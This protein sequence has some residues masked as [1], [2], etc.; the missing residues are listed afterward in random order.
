MVPWSASHNRAA[1]F[2]QDLQHGLQVEGR[3]ADDLEHVGGGGLLLQRFAQLAEQ[4]GI[5]DGDDRLVRKGGHQLDLLGGKRLRHGLVDED[6][7]DDVAFAQQR[8]AQRG[9]VAADLLR[10][11][12]GVFRVRQNVGNVDH[13]SLERDP[14]GHAAAIGADLQ[15]LEIVPDARVHLAGMTVAGDPAE[16][17]A[18]ALEQPGMIGLA[19]PRH[20]LDQRIEH[21]LQVEGRAADDL[22]HVGGGGLLLQ[23]LAQLVEQSGILDGDDRLGGEALDQLDLLVGERA[24][25]LP[26]DDENADQ[27]PFLLQRHGNK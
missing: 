11:A 14:P 16:V 22:E 20:R 7:P 9:A 1:E 17:V 8:D 6:H 19:Q 3:A 15:A 27:L 26:I 21:G 24:H 25:L 18:L 2:D 10:S 23:R 4:A 12:P 13:G 5:L